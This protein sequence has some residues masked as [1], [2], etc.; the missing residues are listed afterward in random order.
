MPSIPIDILRLI[1]DHVDKASLAKICRVNK[2]CC[3]FSQDIL[4]RD[5]IISERSHVPVLQT[6]TDSTHLASRVRLFKMRCTREDEKLLRAFPNMINLRHLDLGYGI[7]LNVLDGCTSALV[8]FACVEA[9]HQFQLLHRFLL[10]QPSVI[11]FTLTPCDDEVWPELGVTCLPNLTRV[12]APLSKLSR[13]IPNRPVKEVTSY[14]FPGDSGDLSCFT[15]STS[16]IQKIEI[17]VV[18]LYQ[19]S[20]QCLASIFPSVAYLLIDVSE[21]I[22]CE[23]HF[24]LITVI[25]NWIAIAH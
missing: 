15:L 4:Y 23:P 7:D 10:S 22:V 19:K 9:S 16:P 1:L 6:L 12:A 21:P 14:M 3:Y 13:L 11:N 2:I 5:I 8:S 24:L 18:H 25:P 20:G 17:D